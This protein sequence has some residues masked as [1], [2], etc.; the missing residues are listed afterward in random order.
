MVQQKIS[1]TKDIN[2]HPIKVWSKIL[3]IL[4]FDALE[5][6]QLNIHKLD[7]FKILLNRISMNFELN[8]GKLINP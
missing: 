2:L 3:K 8:L 1:S 4:S 6:V 5:I 7:T